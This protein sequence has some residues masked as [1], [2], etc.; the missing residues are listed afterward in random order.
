M[1][2]KICN[3]LVA[4]AVSLASSAIADTTLTVKYV[5]AESVYLNGGKADGLSVGDQLT[6]T[7]KGKCQ[8]VIEVVFVADH[9][10][11]CKVTDTTCAVAVGAKALFIVVPKAD[12]TQTPIDSA[13]AAPQP[14]VTIDTAKPSP[15]SY[16]RPALAQFSG[17][18]SFGYYHWTDQ[19]ASHLDFSQSTVRF[20]L[21]ARRLLGQDLTLNLR[22]RGRHDQR[23]RSYNSQVAAKS[24]E[25]RLWEFSLTYNTPTEGFCAQAGRILPRRVSGIGYLDGLLL[26]TR[27]A[28]Q[29]RFGLFGGTSPQ[30]GYAEGQIAINRVGSYAALTSGDP[31]HVYFEQSGAAIGEYHKTFVSREF[32]ALQGRISS[33]GQWSIYHNAEID[34]NRNWRKIKTGTSAN[35]TSIYLGGNYRFNDKLRLGLS[36]DNRTNHWSYEYRTIADSLFDTHLRQGAR[37]QMEL[38]LP[39]RIQSSVSYGLRKRA[40]DSRAT[41]SYSVY[42]NRMGI[43]RRTTMGS[44]QYASFRGPLDIGSNYS[45][46][47]SDYVLPSLSLGC[48]YSVYAYRLDTGGTDRRNRSFEITSQLDLARN[49]FFNGS[50]Q[51]DRGDDTKGTRVQTEVGYRF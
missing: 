6:I 21:K 26:E 47:V 41:T 15:K 7:G 20:D 10:A 25:N 13:V 45:A 12:T 39:W 19:S 33:G 40:G 44:F 51:F 9:S 3:L 36:Y 17:A 49:Y 38:T 24:W 37:A 14:V 1:K 27:L 29:L 4:A 8:T 11:S 2:M 16:A 46:R 35:L 32:I 34:I 48:A 18:V 31:G 28:G 42:L 5:S 50:L 22:S 43:L 23:H 30:W